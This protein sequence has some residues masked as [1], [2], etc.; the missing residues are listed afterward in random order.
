[1]LIHLICN[2]PL[3][4]VAVKY[5]YRI[6]LQNLKVTSLTSPYSPSL[7]FLMFPKSKDVMTADRASCNEHLK[8][9][10]LLRPFSGFPLSITV[11]SQ[12]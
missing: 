1:M 8:R 6:G 10:Y 4:N 3:Y 2:H 9:H 12:S 5:N 11:E 7:F